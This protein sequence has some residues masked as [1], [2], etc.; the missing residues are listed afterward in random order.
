[1]FAFNLRRSKT[2]DR[3]GIPI[4]SF[5]RPHGI[6]YIAR[7]WVLW[8]LID[9]NASSI[10]KVSKMLTLGFLPMQTHSIQFLNLQMQTLMTYDDFERKIVF[11]F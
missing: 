1:M 3:P 7:S 8:E 4:L 2:L 10:H 6:K 9:V 11:P 5:I